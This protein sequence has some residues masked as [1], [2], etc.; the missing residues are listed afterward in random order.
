MTWPPAWPP[1]RGT[2]TVHSQGQPVVSTANIAQLAVDLLIA[3]FSLRV[4][5]VFDSRDLVP[6]VGGREDEEEGIRV[7]T[8]LERE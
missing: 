1:P 7:S 6:V 3:S 2:H 5:G 8:P 4:I